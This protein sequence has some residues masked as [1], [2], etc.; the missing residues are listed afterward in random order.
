ME[1]QEQ[2][3]L[4]KFMEARG[5]KVIKGRAACRADPTTEAAAALCWLRLWRLHTR[6]HMSACSQADELVEQ[7]DSVAPWRRPP[8]PS[9]RRHPADALLAPLPPALAQVGEGEVLDKQAITREA[10]TEHLK[11]QQEL[12]RRLARLARSLDHAERARREEEAPLLAKKREELIKVRAQART[13][14][15][16]GKKGRRRARG[17]GAQGPWAAPASC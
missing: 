1:E 2:A 12:Q 10:A 3:E 15:R 14:G 9:S 8:C 5:K 16:G 7:M 6:G 13:G 4:K 11:Q 17:G